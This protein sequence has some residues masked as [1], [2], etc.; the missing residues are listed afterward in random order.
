[1]LVF[2]KVSE[3]AACVPNETCAWTYTADIPEVTNMITEWDETNHYWTV[4]VT[5]T[6]FAGNTIEETELNVNG[7]P[8]T[9]ISI[10]DTEAIFRVSNIT[11]WTLY[12]INLYFVSGNPKG[13][14]T[15][16]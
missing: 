13:F 11:G 9:T 1:M 15:V 14:D 12:N 3:E 7:R 5:G 8:Q 6:N 4:V 10:S 16:I 2:L